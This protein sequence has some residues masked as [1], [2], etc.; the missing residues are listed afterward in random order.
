MSLRAKWDR[1]SGKIRSLQREAGAKAALRTALTW[2]GAFLRKKALNMSARA[3]DARTGLDTVADFPE[4]ERPENPVHDDAVFYARVST[5]IFGRLL[6]D[7]GVAPEKFA[8][9]DLGCGKGAPLVLA[10]E[11]GFATVVGVELNGR[12]ASVAQSNAATY[13]RRHEAAVPIQVVQG[14]V[15]NFEWPASST[16]VFLF[17]PFGAETLRAV[18]GN[19]EASLRAHPRDVRVAYVSPVHAQVLEDSGLFERMPSRSPR[20]AV[21]RHTPT[22]S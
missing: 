10:A 18:L 2:S 9:V 21:Y 13:A 3:Y 12:L 1:F 6:E 19:L 11:H 15:V 22:G 17:N 14:D 4:V 8:F 16:V 7:L 20:W 5:R